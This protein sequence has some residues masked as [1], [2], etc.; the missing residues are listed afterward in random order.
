MSDALQAGRLVSIPEAMMA[1]AHRAAARELDPTGAAK[2]LRQIGLEA[3][4][5]L[6]DQFW[7]WVA[8]TRMAV[9]AEPGNIDFDDFWRRLS[10][11]FDQLGFGTLDLEQLHPGVFALSS[12]NWMEANISDGDHQGCQLTTGVLAGFLRLVA[13]QDLAVLEVECR[14]SGDEQCRFVAGSPEALQQIFERMQLGSSFSEAVATL[15]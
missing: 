7:D 5:A 8:G 14:G 4:P 10:D 11:F 3:G 13:E 9:P 12:D 1:A 2:L 15:S 6:H